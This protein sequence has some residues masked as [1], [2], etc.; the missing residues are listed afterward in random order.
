MRHRFS[1]VSVLVC[2]ALLT[3]ACGSGSADLSPDVAAHLDAY[4][5]LIEQFEPKFDTV[6]NDPPQFATV[7]ASY[8]RQTK[9]WIDDWSNIAPDLSEDEGRAVESIV[10]KLNRRAEKMLTGR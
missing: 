8:T 4:E 1:A 9:A 7:S 5:R 3:C 10:K 2:L 6:R